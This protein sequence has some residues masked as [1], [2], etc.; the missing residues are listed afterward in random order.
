M[1]IISSYKTTIP[2]SLYP[3]R[4]KSLLGQ[5][6]NGLS[7]FEVTKVAPQFLFFIPPR[8]SY[9]SLV[10]QPTPVCGFSFLVPTWKKAFSKIFFFLSQF[11][12]FRIRIENWNLYLRFYDLRDPIRRIRAWSG[13]SAASTSSAARS[14]ADR[15]V[16]SS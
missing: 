11:L 2:V 12:G 4:H 10:A 7:H 9:L 13:S 6:V 3:F 5:L 1:T 8:P 15:S 16:K 14:A